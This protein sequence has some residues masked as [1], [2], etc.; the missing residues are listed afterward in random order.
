MRGVQ[1]VVHQYFGSPPN[2]TACHN[3]STL[4][5][6]EATNATT[7]RELGDPCCVVLQPSS[8]GCAVCQ[9]GYFRL[10]KNCDPC[11]TNCASCAEE[12]TN[13]LACN[14]AFT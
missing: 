3:G 14:W 11:H 2:C 7:C 9:S 4:V 13:C 10:N 12:A 1:L 5:T 6:D 8:G